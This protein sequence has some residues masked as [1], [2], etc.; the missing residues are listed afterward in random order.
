[1]AHVTKS[2]VNAA[3]ETRSEAKAGFSPAPAKDVAEGDQI[4]RAQQG[5]V[6]A[7]EELVRKHQRRVM[8]IV[9]GILRWR[10]DVEDVAQQVFLKVYLSIQR[11]DGRSSFSTW[12]YKITLNET[13]DHLRKKKAR[14][15]TYESD[16]SEEQVRHIHETAGNTRPGNP[17][18]LALE[19]IESRQLVSRLLAELSPQDRMMLVLKEVEGFSVE[20]ISAIMSQN[21][22]TVKVRMFRARRR[23]AE[24]YR[25][26]FGSRMR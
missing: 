23:L 26:R 18:P 13:Y 11:F 7:Y 20:E 19:R 10:D 1:M 15:L 21:T 2:E 6:S 9:G 17:S 25:K 24:L 16:L 22:N 5:D 14:R 3:L 8:A 4:R 12:L